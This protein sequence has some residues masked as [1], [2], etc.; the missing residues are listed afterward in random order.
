MYAL[1]VGARP[2]ALPCRDNELIRV[3]GDVAD[4]VTSGVGGSMAVGFRE[5]DGFRPRATG[6]VR[7]RTA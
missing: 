6:L 5:T 7:V 3:L 4:L 1:H 2:G